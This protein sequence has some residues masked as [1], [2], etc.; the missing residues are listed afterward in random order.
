MREMDLHRFLDFP[1]WHLEYSGGG[2][3][4]ALIAVFHVF[5][6]LFAVGAGPYLVRLEAAA[7]RR[8][9]AALLDHVRAH[10]RFFLVVTTVLGTISGVG[11]WFII[12]VLSPAATRHLVHKFL[13]FWAAEWAF[14][15]AEIL[16]LLLYY[17]GFDRMRSRA[18]MTVGWIYAA[19]GWLSLFAVNGIVT[20]MLTPGDAADS[21]LTAAF[22]N[23]SFWP[24]LWIRTGFAAL[25]AGLFGLITAT[26]LPS[27]KRNA[28]VCRFAVKWI[29]GAVAVILLTG[30]W[31]MAA[32]NPERQA[33]ILNLSPETGGPLKLFFW[34]VPFLLA[35]GGLL[36]LRWPPKFKQALAAV[37]LVLGLAWFGCFEH[38]REAGRRPW[39]IPGRLYANGLAAA[40]LS[41]AASQGVLHS[42]RWVS[43]RK[44]TDSSRLALGEEIFH[45]M[46]ASCHSVGGVMQDI[47]PAARPFTREGLTSL[48]QGMGNVA[49]HM[50]PFPGNAAE[51]DALAAWLVAR[52]DGPEPVPAPDPRTAPPAEAPALAPFDPASDEYVLLAWPGQGMNCVSDADDWFNFRAPGSDIE[53]VLIRRGP[54]PEM[55]SSGVRLIYR[56]E[57]GF[58]SPAD[59]VA[60]WE[61]SR[62]LLGAHLKKNTGV[63]GFGPAGV[64]ARMNDRFAA[65]RV[66]VMPYAADGFFQPYPLADLTAVSPDGAQIAATRVTVPVSTEMNCRRCH[67]GP[68]R[69]YDRAGISDATARHIL[70]THDR[71]N[72][73][74]LLDRALAGEPA[75][76]QSCHHEAGTTRLNFSAAI[77]GFHAP[78]MAEGTGNACA[79]CH[80]GD[81]AGHTHAFRGLHREQA[82]T[83]ANCHGDMAFHAASLLNAEAEKPAAPALLAALAGI[84]AVPV[85]QV[86]ARRPWVQLPD[87]LT[88]HI[89]FGPPETDQAAGVWTSG[90]GDRFRDRTGNAGI[91]CM[92]CHGAAHA[93]YPARHPENGIVRDNLG[94][95][96]Y[97]GMPYPMG[98]NRNCRVCHTGDMEDEMHHPGALSMFRNTI[99]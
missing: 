77:H 50:P 96:Q 43:T 70:D 53:A 5:I 74:R 20:Y 49:S 52:T 33:Y 21:S 92:A 85:D 76:C 73:T 51:R 4:V 37:M 56:L 27:E 9:S 54:L 44:I 32:L 40:D 68:W 19:F 11:I 18:H 28:F 34:T 23:P 8:R 98:A 84:S 93:L 36:A 26:R 94:P 88:C 95:L 58:R 83:C 97:Q 47:L 45:L 35:G 82:L 31:Y 3:W 72:R 89:D 22:F 13:F 39:L 48:M 59:A 75:R 79:A 71:L 91:P 87:C 55:I 81:P 24:S 25:L 1:A 10:A 6:A 67:G 78:L 61:N 46:C 17:Y 80:P 41:T 14:F 64:M 30:W 7:C 99:N 12:S 60:F 16:T 62:A 65:D 86:P 90:R 66:P 63:S 29:I 57:D 2:F 42:A 15:L 38:L 69:K